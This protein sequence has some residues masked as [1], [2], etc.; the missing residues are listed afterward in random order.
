MQLQFIDDPRDALNKATRYELFKFARDNGVTEI[1]EGMP[2]LYMRQVLRSRGLTRI[3]IPDRVLGTPGGVPGAREIANPSSPAD[4][5][6][7]DAVSDLQRQWMAQKIRDETEAA[8]PKP[9]TNTE[10]TTIGSLRQAAK[11]AGIKLVR[12]DTAEVIRQKLKAI[13]N[14]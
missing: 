12:T 2:A 9:Q 7:V 14:G 1:E 11:A 10:H 4:T 3:N 6:T 8:A 13:D 5:T